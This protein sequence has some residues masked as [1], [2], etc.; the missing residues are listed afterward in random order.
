MGPLDD[1]S[2]AGPVEVR[3]SGATIRLSETMPQP[4]VNSEAKIAIKIKLARRSW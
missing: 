3:K 4:N 2:E 1:V